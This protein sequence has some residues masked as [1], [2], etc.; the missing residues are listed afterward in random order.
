MLKFA[1]VFAVAVCSTVILTGC[2]SS[3]DGEAKKQDG[4]VD[5]FKSIF[6]EKKEL[7]FYPD[8]LTDGGEEIWGN[9]KRQDDDIFSVLEK[10]IWGDNEE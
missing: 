8:G 4:L 10:K 7:E 6:L 2:S 3:D 5:S 9:G 1:K